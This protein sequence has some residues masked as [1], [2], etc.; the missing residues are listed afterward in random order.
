MAGGGNGVITYSDI[1]L[2]NAPSS[3]SAIHDNVNNDSNYS[4]VSGTGCG[5]E[6]L[7][8]SSYQKQT[9]KS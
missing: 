7:E 1:A 2:G 8:S 9:C 3:T 6:L 5:T 4:V